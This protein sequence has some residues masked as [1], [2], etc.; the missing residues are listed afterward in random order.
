MTDGRTHRGTT[1]TDFDTKLIYP[2]FLKK[3][4]GIIIKHCVLPENVGH[5]KAGFFALIEVIVSG[6]SVFL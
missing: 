3:K 5:L 6:C 1:E 4:A 2:F